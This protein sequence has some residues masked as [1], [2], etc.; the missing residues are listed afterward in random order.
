MQFLVIAK[1]L[2]TLAGQQGDEQIRAAL[3]PQFGRILSS[4]KVI[5]SGFIGGMRGAFFIVEIEAAEE[6]YAVFGPEVYGNCEL[7][8]Y[9]IFALEK[10]AEFFQQW[11]AEGR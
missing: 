4:G 9:P 8:T 7:E 5:N 11:A 10:G 2:P 6:L 3:G 1:V